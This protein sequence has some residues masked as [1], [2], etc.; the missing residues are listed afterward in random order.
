[1][2]DTTTSALEHILSQTQ[3]M[4]ATTKEEDWALLCELEEQRRQDIAAFFVDQKT[5]SEP[6]R[7]ILQEIIQLDEQTEVL[8]RQAQDK[9]GHDIRQFSKGQNVS[10]QYLETV[11]LGRSR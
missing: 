6:Q 10:K 3:N 11:S 9:L 7:C 5:L 4:L 2:T 8:S 1:M